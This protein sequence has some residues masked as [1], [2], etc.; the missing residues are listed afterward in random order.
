MEEDLLLEATQLRRGLDSELVVEPATKP[1]ER[2]QRLGLPA[3]PVQ[4]EHQLSR[5]GRSRNGCSCTCVSNS[6]TSSRRQ[7]SPQIGLDTHLDRGEPQ[8]FEPGTLAGANS[9]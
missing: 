6:P 3:G 1:L 7:P 4:G 2:P 5:L 8:L 9:S